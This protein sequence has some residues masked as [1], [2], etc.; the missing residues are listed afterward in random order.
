MAERRRVIFGDTS[1]L[2]FEAPILRAE[3]EMLHT[4]DYIGGGK[5]ISNR[6]LREMDGSPALEWPPVLS[7]YDPRGHRSVGNGYVPGKNAK[8]SRKG[9]PGYFYSHKARGMVPHHSD[10][11]KRLLTALELCPYVVE[12]R[13][14]YQEW[15][16]DY[17]AEVAQ[18]GRRIAR[19]KIMTIDIMVTLKIPGYP[20]VIYHAIS[21]KPYA[22]VG[23]QENQVR[24]TKERNKVDG[25]GT[26]HEVMTELTISQ[27]EYSNNLLLLAYMRN[28]EDIKELAESAKAL[29]DAL[30]RTRVRGTLDRVIKIVGR[31]FGWDLN[32][33]YRIFAVANFLGHLVWNHDFKLALD[34]P[35]KL[36]KTLT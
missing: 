23:K 19:N 11:E 12:I 10:L 29:A 4:V 16:E 14:Q 35:M 27:M 8:A 30:N 1:D 24:H 26:T 6:R 21:G 13:A 18:Q 17:L 20:D 3:M 32:T 34:K 36:K 9:L 7:E 25:W 33:G 28:V 2:M 15:D 22:L 5:S 31:R